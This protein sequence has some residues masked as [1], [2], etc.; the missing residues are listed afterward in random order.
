MTQTSTQKGDV[1]TISKVSERK[2]LL[3]NILIVSYICIALLFFA[4]LMAEKLAFLELA[5][6]T[7]LII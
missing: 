3:F 1:K 7:F 6:K 4:L 2:I 5:G